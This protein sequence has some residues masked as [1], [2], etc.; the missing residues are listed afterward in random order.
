MPPWDREEAPKPWPPM[1]WSRLVALLGAQVK[2]P[3]GIG[4]L[5][6][7]LTPSEGFRLAWWRATWTVWYEDSPRPWRASYRT[8][9]VKETP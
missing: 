9:E 5:I 8:D 7:C 4:T 2:T 3:D 1:E 6:G